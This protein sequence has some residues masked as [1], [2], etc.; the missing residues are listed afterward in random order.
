[1]AR[2]MDVLELDK[3]KDPETGLAL[4]SKHPSGAET[5]EQSRLRLFWQFQFLQWRA[6]RAGDVLAVA[7]ALICCRHFHK[8]PPWLCEAA[9]EL[10]ERRM[11]DEDKLAYGHL[12]DHLMRF[13]AVQLVR[14]QRPWD[15]RNNN[16][17][18]VLGDQV[19]E[20]AAK[21]LADTGINCSGE[22]VRKS[23]TLIRRAGGDHVTLPSY[24][25]AVAERDRRR[26]KKN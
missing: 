1:M 24:R 9:L 13:Q 16:K 26:K 10:C 11:S 19:W 3:V 21:M 15:A 20:D 17:K 6:W 18:K 23:H 4:L 12:T 22:T 5:P 2:D 25:R 14:G 8:V 7:R